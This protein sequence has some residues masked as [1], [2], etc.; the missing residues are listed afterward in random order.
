MLGEWFGPERKEAGNTGRLGRMEKL[1]V[2]PQEVC[3]NGVGEDIRSEDGEDV[4]LGSRK[5]CTPDGLGRA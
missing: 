5:G 3:E 1:G 2:G 4:R